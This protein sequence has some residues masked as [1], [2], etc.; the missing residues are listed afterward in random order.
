MNIDLLK[1]VCVV[2]I[3]SSIITTSTVQMI[4]S[5]VKVSNSKMFVWLSL[6]ISLTIGT[7]FAKCFSSLSWLNCL[8][9]GFITWLGA[10]AIYHSL[11]EK[12]FTPLSKMNKDK[13][14][15]ITEEDFE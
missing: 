2:A 12:I 7:F 9:S 1:T 15:K 10:E 4:K 3:A 11:E 6:G 5:G 8:W 14:I 13:Q